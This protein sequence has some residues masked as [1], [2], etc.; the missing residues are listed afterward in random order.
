MLAGGGLALPGASPPG[1]SAYL[2]ST[3]SCL[4]PATLCQD[5]HTC[6]WERGWRSEE[7]EG[8]GT[9][10]LHWAGHSAHRHLQ[11]MAQRQRQSWSKG[12]ACQFL[13]SPEDEPLP[14]RL[15]QKA[16]SPFTGHLP[17]VCLV[18]YPHTFIQ[19]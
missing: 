17:A 11:L 8:T 6:T 18:F 16:F 10:S 5:R 15:D 19:S 13:P 3:S 14:T 7:Q 12:K 1:R 9:H 4:G 2:G